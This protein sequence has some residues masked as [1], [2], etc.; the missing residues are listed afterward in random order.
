MAKLAYGI[1]WHL[2][3]V[4]GTTTTFKIGHLIA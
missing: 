4:S 2:D 1:T 3:V